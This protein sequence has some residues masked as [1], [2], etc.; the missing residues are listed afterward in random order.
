LNLVGQ[1]STSL[2]VLSSYRRKG[3]HHVTQIKVAKAFSIVCH[4]SVKNGS[5]GSWKGDNKDG[6]LDYFRGNPLLHTQFQQAK[7]IV[8]TVDN[9][10][11]IHNFG[12]RIHGR[13]RANVVYKIMDTRRH[14]LSC[15]MV[16]KKEGDRVFLFGQLHLVQ[17]LGQ[18]GLYQ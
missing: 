7:V 8:K 5:G 6:F 2:Y 16:A 1:G 17:T 9:S 15:L 18:G 10:R 14:V 13:T 3:R 11:T 12:H 4:G